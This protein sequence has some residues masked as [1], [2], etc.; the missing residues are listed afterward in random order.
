MSHLQSMAILGIRSFSPDEPCYIKFF[1][2]LTLIV[3][4]NGA[5]KTTIIESLRYACTGDLPPNSKN[6][7]FVNDPK[8]AGINEVKA[9]IKLKFYNINGQKM[10]CSRSLAVT[11]KKTTVTQR[12]IDNALLR[13]DPVT[14]E[15][16]SITSRCTDMDSELPLHLGVP[17]AILDNVI[18]CHQ[19]DSNWPLSEPST[20]KK[21]FDDIFSSKRF[22][23]A[24]DNIKEIRKEAA[25]D[26]KMGNVQLEALQNDTKKAK[27]VRSNLT[28]LNQQM[29]AKNETLQTIE[30]KLAQ[31][32]AE[33][34]RLTASL[35]DNQEA[36]DKIRQLMNQRDFFESTMRS[37]E[38]HIEPREES[39]EQLQHLLQEHRIKEDKNQ[40]EKSTVTLEKSKLE[41]QLKRIQ[42]ELSQKQVAMGR[43]DAAR[44]EYLRQIQRRSELIQKMNEDKNMNL[45]VDDGDAS[46]L[47][48]K[49][50]IED[51]ATNNEKAKDEAMSKQNALSDELQMLRSQK[52]SI[53]ENKKHLKRLIIEL[54]AKKVKE[55]Q[56]SEMQIESMKVKIA[57]YVSD[58]KCL[59]E[60]KL[61]E[62]DAETVGSSHDNL[63]KK[64]HELRDVDD[65]ISDLNEESARL[66]KQS[67]SRAKLSLKRTE[68]EVKETTVNRIYNDHIN[69]IQSLLGSKP[70]ME[71]LE[72]ELDVYKTK[73]EKELASLIEVRNKA[74]RE[75]SAADA[76]VN[77]VLQNYNKQKREADKFQSLIEKVCG[78]GD[79][80]A[81]LADTEKKADAWQ[82]KIAQIQGASIVYQKFRNTEDQSRCCPL[83]TRD[84]ENNDE[85]EMFRNQL[86]LMQDFI[87]EKQQKMKDQLKEIEARKSKLLSAQGTWIKLESLRKDLA[88]ISETK[89]ALEAEKK[90][91]EERNRIATEQLVQV[92]NCKIKADKL[93]LIA[94]NVS[95]LNREVEILT[96]DVQDLEKELEFSGSVR[97]SDDVMKELEELTERSKAIRRD[98]KRIH[99]EIDMN[100]RKRQSVERAL[101]ESSQKLIRL[102]NERD[103]KVGMQIQLDDI[104]EQRA[105]R[106]VEYERPENNAEPLTDKIQAAKRLYDEAVKNWRIVE[107]KASME[108]QKISV[109]AER[110]SDYNAIIRKCAAAASP[111]KVESLNAEITNLNNTIADIK[112]RV[113]S[114]DEKLAIIEKDE[115]ERRGIERDLQ[116]QIKYR[117]MQKQLAKCEEELAAADQRQ[118]QVDV[119][120][121]QRNLQ[122]AR[123]EQ[124]DLVDKRGGIRGEIVQMRDQSRRYEQELRTDY[125]D[126]DGR[127]GNLF[128]EVKTKELASV[129]LEKYSKVL[130]TAIMKYHSLKM[131]DLNKIIKE[132]W[133]DTYKGGDIDYIEIRAD[134]EGSTASR[135]FNYRVV[136]IQN[137]SELNMR[138]RCSAGQ[139]VL[140]A[141]IIRLALAETFCVNCGIFTL[142]EPT[143]NLDRANIES[144]AEN[145]GRIIKNRSQQSNFQFVIITHDEE[146]VEYL[147]RDNILGQYYRVSKDLK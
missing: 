133:V 60:K 35:S 26:I 101:N 12:T 76:K 3:G 71:N 87:P 120:S 5:G 107:E 48:I 135:T 121:L 85:I 18:F 54:L 141:I 143:T 31:I 97:T 57:E 112:R 117:D 19:E 28:E 78:K 113:A 32:E 105:S 80:P 122:R 125:Q 15:A 79:L 124:S 139:K 24:L 102:E 115:A 147:S 51:N 142:D 68:K 144:L 61:A 86:K 41:R 62:M 50:L 111:E 17:K 59:Y 42:D 36:H 33:I 39:T 128:I 134:N 91:A 34:N 37:I 82:T 99:T 45:P 66:S 8:V 65:K 106:S 145:L 40:E 56:V 25:A 27:R 7:A 138:G 2:P 75:L 108:E 14:G 140:A 69:D 30:T 123:K 118:N 74:N 9:Q 81:E 6:G 20:L 23:A 52:M 22:T 90:T 95:N 1:S 93:L 114:I 4:S 10:V 13:Y 96:Q 63:K 94:R 104:K 146:F 83:C 21:K 70:S 136:M 88:S 127:Y 49:E 72:R 100:N 119:V 131:Q 43:L 98:M 55:F 132:L 110:L 116:D 64:E 73:K 89:D 46:S 130:Q 47:A 129:D 92:D 77:M 11:Q 16:F 67:D 137:G 29:A 109:F 103:R 44:D 53:E 84:F 126:V 58:E 38:A